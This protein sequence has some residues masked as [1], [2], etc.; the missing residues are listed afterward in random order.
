MEEQKGATSQKREVAEQG[1]KY[2]LVG[3]ASALIELA[4]FHGMNSLLNLPIPPSNIT[5]IVIATAFNFLMN[6]NVTFKSTSNPL[7]SLVLYLLL[8]AANMA[9][10]T[11]AIM[12]L[13]NIG[14]PATAAK[15]GTMC[16]IVAW[17]FVLYRKVIFK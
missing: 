16:C 8:F 12:L 14:V 17:N 7:R 9:F 6:R 5:A 13:A 3:G 10:S 1:V 11:F 4:I 2:L 15:V